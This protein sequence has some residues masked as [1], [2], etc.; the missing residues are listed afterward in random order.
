MSYL[1]C[2]PSFNEADNIA[3][4]LEELR[5]YGYTDIIVSDANSSDGTADI[6]RSMGALVLPRSGHGKGFAIKDVLFY[7][8]EHNFEALILLDCDR[9][10]PISSIAELISSFINVDMVV[11]CRNF[12]DISF[13][14]RLANH[15]M[16]AWTNLFFNTNV[17]DMAT[18]MRMLRVEKFV[19]NITAK[20]FDVEPQMHCLALKN[21]WRVKEID[22]SYKTRV[23][24][25]KIN[26][27][28][29]FLILYRVVVERFKN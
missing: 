12:K 21:K 23:G 18:G 2:L 13:L 28:H 25:S 6:A 20:S 27:S 14:R 26:L 1:I 10:Y 8:K 7:A 16:T 4:M 3:Y 9:T 15:L 29:L 24:E 5:S 19:G 17:K 22:I 11:A